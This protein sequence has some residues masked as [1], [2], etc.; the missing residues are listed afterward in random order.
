MNRM[1][2]NRNMDKNDDSFIYEL[3]FSTIANISNSDKSN[4]IKIKI[5]RI[6]TK[7]IENILNAE[8]QEDNVLEKY[9]CS[10]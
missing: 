7:L 3:V 1:N 6:I 10:H 4:D 5:I 8:K 2:E 9:G